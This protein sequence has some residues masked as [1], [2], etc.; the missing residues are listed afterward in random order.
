[1]SVE[2]ISQMPGTSLDWKKWLKEGDQY[3]KAVPKDGTKSRFGTDIRYNL[4]SE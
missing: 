1:M 4:L 3:F 2:I